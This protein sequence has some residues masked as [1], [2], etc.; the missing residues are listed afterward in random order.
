MAE[1]PDCV[2]CREPGGRI[3][4]ETTQW[5]IVLATEAD[6]LSFPGFTRVIWQ[7]HTREMSSLSAPDQTTFMT[8][9]FSV[10][11]L[12]LKY[13]NP[14]K[15]NLASLGNMVDHLHWHVIPRWQEDSHFPRPVWAAP[16]PDRKPFQLGPDK[17]EQ[18]IEAVIEHFSALAADHSS[19]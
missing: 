6:A 11:S 5:R 7:A 9:V 10:E 1:T 2:L 12:M 4:V 19:G 14:H 16:V 18:Y 15:V 17:L 3:L 13:L 8:L